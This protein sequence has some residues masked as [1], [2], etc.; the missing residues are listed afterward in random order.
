M[1][2]CE[3]SFV[4]VEQQPAGTTMPLRVLFITLEFSA[5]TFSGNGVCAQSQVLLSTVSSIQKNTGSYHKLHL[6]G[7]APLLTVFNCRPFLVLFGLAATRLPCLSS[8]HQQALSSAFLH[9]CSG[10]GMLASRYER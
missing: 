4:D 9:L 6:Q 2:D 10:V 7:Y 3:P 5:A 1:D 8:R